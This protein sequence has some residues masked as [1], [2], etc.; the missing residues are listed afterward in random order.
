MN[1]LHHFINSDSVQILYWQ[2][3]DKATIL[4]DIV[5]RLRRHLTTDE[6]QTGHSVVHSIRS[7]FV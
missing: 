6:M 5:L 7:N 4:C 3:H 2:V 1:S